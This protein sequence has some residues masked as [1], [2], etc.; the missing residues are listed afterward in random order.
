MPAFPFDEIMRRARAGEPDAQRE[1]AN[2]YGPHI[3]DYVDRVLNSRGRAR[4]DVEDGVESVLVAFFLK[5]LLTKTFTNQ[6]Q[7][8]TYLRGMARFR[9]HKVNRR[10]SA[11][12]RDIARTVALPVNLAA[13]NA[14]PELVAAQHD[15]WQHFLATLSPDEREVFILRS[16]GFDTSR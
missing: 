6:T 2:R 1:F 3:R 4:F 12:K 5:V 14:Q 11:A 9:M 8:L 16:E 13:A 7:L 15:S 10:L